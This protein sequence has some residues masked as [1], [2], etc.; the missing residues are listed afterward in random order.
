M[1]SSSASTSK[2]GLSERELQRKE[3][4]LA[5]NY[6]YENDL[7]HSEDTI[8]QKE[9]FPKSSFKEFLN[10]ISTMEKSRKK[11]KPNVT[12]R[13]PAKTLDSVDPVTPMEK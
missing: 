2:R 4:Q 7:T 12:C 11:R 6:G 8:L 13:A 1:S 3:E 5:K 9:S 10:N